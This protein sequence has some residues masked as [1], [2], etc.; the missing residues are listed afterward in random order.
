MRC[1]CLAG[2]ELKRED[3]M[4]GF[5]TKWRFRFSKA[6]LST[7]Q[8]PHQNCSHGPVGRPRRAAGAWL[9]TRVEN[10]AGNFS[11]PIGN[12]QRPITISSRARDFYWC[13]HFFI[14][15]CLVHL[16]FVY[17]E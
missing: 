15:Y 6:L 11:F 5:G 1:N 9:Q 2:L 14:A 12:L 17:V 13:C 4:G 7:T 10:I 3:E 16:F 8:P